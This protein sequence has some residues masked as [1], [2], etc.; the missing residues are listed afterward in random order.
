M[1]LYSIAFDLSLDTVE[2]IVLAQEDLDERLSEVD[3]EFVW[4]DPT[5]IRVPLKV[6]RGLDEAMIE[7]VQESVELVANALVPFK[8][9]V[10][11]LLVLPSPSQPRLVCAPID[12][13]IDLVKGLQKVLDIHLERIGIP[14]DSRE[15]RAWALAGRVRSE[16]GVVDLGPLI[17]ELLEEGFGDSFVTHI[18]IFEGSIDRFGEKWSVNR[19]FRLGGARHKKTA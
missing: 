8:V 15:Y 4:N 6:M 7:R 1:R 14:L 9:S 3:A 5:L 13:G 16:G 11:G 19:R 2:N 17:S 10:G 12:G 18:A